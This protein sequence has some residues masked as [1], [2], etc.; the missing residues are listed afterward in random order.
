MI[1][2]LRLFILYSLI[3]F[4]LTSCSGSKACPV[5]EP[6][7]VLPPED[8][9]VMNEPAYGYY[10]V[11]EDNSIWASAYWPSEEYHLRAGEDGN[12]IGWFRPAGA[13]LEV[14][15]KRLDGQAP[16]LKAE[17]PCCYSTRFQASGLYFP[18]EG[19]WEITARATDR[20]LTFVVKVGP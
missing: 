18:T 7:W 1:S 14:K 6:A 3:P 13:A 2:P 16:A 20:V 8:S 15:G 12:K 10:Y 9:A 11:N 4:V 5:T 19:C 17:F